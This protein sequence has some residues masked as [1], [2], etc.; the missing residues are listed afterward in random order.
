M[1]ANC[2]PLPGVRDISRPGREAEALLRDYA[3]HT[4]KVRGIYDDLFAFTGEEG[5]AESAVKDYSALLDPETPEQEAVSLLEKLGF[6]DPGK[7]YRDLLLLREGTAFVHQT[8]RSRKL[9]NEIFPPLFQEIIASPDPDMALN[10]LE[11]FLAAQGSWEAFQS[12][13]RIDPSAGKVLIAVFANSEYLSRMLVSRP[14]L[15]Q[16]LIES[17]KSSGVGTCAGFAKELGDALEQAPDITEKLDA[18]RRFKHLEEIRIGMAD[19]LSN[20]PLP[21][22]LPRSV[23]A[24]GGL[25]RRRA[26]ACGIGNRQAVQHAG[27]D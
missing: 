15:L 27:V 24:R 20:M 25:S 18:L 1:N 13:M 9:F 22:G 16:N 6:R 8:P 21:G 3:D 14:V 7:A 2:A 23:E 12:L 17:R 4:K 26:Y 10:H 11:S 5:A 19:L